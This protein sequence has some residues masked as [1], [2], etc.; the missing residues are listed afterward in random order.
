[1][2][3]ESHK[4]ALN[5]DGILARSFGQE[6]HVY[7]VER[8]K[9]RQIKTTA[10]RLVMSFIS[11]KPLQVRK[12]AFAIIKTTI[13]GAQRVLISAVYQISINPN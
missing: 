11:F 1:M 4:Q 5:M 12:L 6:L 7:L 9:H 2:R 3:N 8:S 13:E 10:K